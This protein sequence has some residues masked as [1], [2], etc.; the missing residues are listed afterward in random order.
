MQGNSQKR[1]I[2]AEECFAWIVVRGVNS[3]SSI[4]LRHVD[5]STVLTYNIFRDVTIYATLS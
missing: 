4:E 3:L 5:E 1:T 2:C